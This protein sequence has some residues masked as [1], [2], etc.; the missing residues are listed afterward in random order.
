MD[1]LHTSNKLCT[2]SA[3]APTHL[4]VETHHAADDLPSAPPSAS[5]SNLAITQPPSPAYAAFPESTPPPAAGLDSPTSASHFALAQAKAQ[6][7]ELERRLQAHTEGDHGDRLDILQVTPEANPSAKMTATTVLADATCPMRQSSVS[8]RRSSSS[9]QREKSPARRLGVAAATRRRF[10]RATSLPLEDEVTLARSQM[11]HHYYQQ[12]RRTGS[13][14]NSTATSSTMSMATPMA[15]TEHMAEDRDRQGAGPSNT[16]VDE[17]L[18]AATPSDGLENQ[19]PFV[20]LSNNEQ[21]EDVSSIPFSQAQRES[22]STIDGVSALEGEKSSFAD[23]SVRKAE[24]SFVQAQ[25]SAAPVTPAQ[26][27]AMHQFNMPKAAPVVPLPPTLNSRPSFPPF[28]IRTH[29]FTQA[30]RRLLPV[31]VLPSR[32]PS[33]SAVSI[34]DAYKSSTVYAPTAVAASDPAPVFS[35]AVPPVTNAQDLRRLQSTASIPGYVPP[36]AKETLKELDLHEVLQCRQLR[37][38]VVFDANLMF[39]PNFDG[40]RGDRKREA[41]DRYW[42]AVTRELET[43]C[44]CTAYSFAPSATARMMGRP[45]IPLPCIC[46]NPAMPF[47]T[48]SVS[49]RLPSRILPLIQE[50]RDILLALLPQPGSSTFGANGQLRSTGGSATAQMVRETLDPSLIA[51]EVSHG[52]LDVASLATFFGHILKAHCAP[53]RDEVVE[54]MIRTIKQG[55]ERSDMSM[56]ANGLRMCFEILE[57]MKLDVANHQLRMLRPYLLETA[58]DFEYKTFLRIREKRP[59]HSEDTATTAQL[60]EIAGPPLSKTRVWISGITERNRAAITATSSH[61]STAFVVDGVLE[62]LFNP[63]RDNTDPSNADKSQAVRQSGL[64]E[65][66]KAPRT[67]ALPLVSEVPETFQLDTY[68]L[69][70]FHG[71]VVDLCIVHLLILLYRQL[72]SVNK[73]TPTLEDIEVMRRQIW[74]I[75]SEINTMAVAAP[76]GNGRRTTTSLPQSLRKLDSEHWREG[77]KDVLLQISRYSAGNDSTNGVAFVP[78]VSTLNLLNSWMENSFRSDSKLFQLVQTRLRRALSALILSEIEQHERSLSGKPWDMSSVEAALEA[79]SE[80]DSV[81]KR[82]GLADLTGEVRL[83]ASR[84]AKVVGYNVHVFKQLYGEL[85]QEK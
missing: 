17:Q 61:D 84:I 81:M 43:G 55:G 52:V 50:L 60:A 10:R 24:R 21:G 33:I 5:F 22:R 83:L 79:R 72:C 78:D 37:H 56:V 48:T 71:D 8:S 11:M 85:L 53:M 31:P 76:A 62:L 27:S 69:Q 64:V 18:V 34:N 74:V 47:V 57:L 32:L 26:L 38:D 82:N 35:Q 3:R 45:S 1:H 70:L 67:Q 44:K 58:A 73:R 54:I 28:P 12:H 41:A 4:E 13:T 9:P 6:E 75:M 40:D 29:P 19:E 39:R 14:P 36:I 15:S 20:N 63:K 51:Q 46:R 30:Q 2:S 80:L 65:R 42:T 7:A 77:M 25:A 16:G 59:Q 23:R 68:R 49:Q 66:R